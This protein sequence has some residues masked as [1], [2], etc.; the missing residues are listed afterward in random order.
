MQIVLIFEKD[1]SDSAFAGSV[2]N[3][4]FDPVKQEVIIRTKKL[5][6]FATLEKAFDNHGLE[7]FNQAVISTA[8]NQSLEIAYYKRELNSAKTREEMLKAQLAISAK[9]N[10]VLERQL[11]AITV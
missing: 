10:E 7:G 1:G 3:T 5:T 8:A 11:N 4:S 6:T 9:Q 2:S